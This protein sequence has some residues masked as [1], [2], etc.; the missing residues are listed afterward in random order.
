MSEPDQI[1]DAR[2]PD[3]R[4]RIPGRRRRPAGRRSPVGG[5]AIRP[6]V[7]LA[8]HRSPTRRARVAGRGGQGI[9]RAARLT[10]P[11]RSAAARPRAPPRRPGASR[12][13]AASVAATWP[14]SH[15]ASAA[16]GSGR[17]RSANRPVS[18]ACVMDDAR[19]RRAVGR[20]AGAEDQ[21]FGVVGGVEESAGPPARNRFPSTEVQQRRRPQS[22]QS[23]LTRRP[24][25]APAVRRP[26]R[27]DRPALRAGADRSV[28]RD[29]GTS[30]RRPGGR[31]SGSRARRRRPR[32]TPAGRAAAPASA[33][34]PI[35]RPLRPQHDEVVPAG[36]RPLARRIEQTL[37]GH[38]GEPVGVRRVGRQ[39]QHRTGQ[40]RDRCVRSVE[41]EACAAASASPSSAPSTSL[42]FA[43][44]STG[45]S[46]PRRR[47]C[48]RPATRRTPPWTVRSSREQ[49][50]GHLS[51]HPGRQ[52][53]PGH[54]GR[55]G[56]T[57]R[58]SC[59]LS[60]SIFS[61]CGTCQD[62][63]TL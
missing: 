26:D 57:R 43:R 52:R 7:R 12:P 14:P 25:T 48:R 54:A 21:R 2:S 61:K 20:V 1:R 35:A 63:S 5:R 50:F 8:D 40:L 30:G 19:R 38:V 15:G 11:R 37:R 23:R 45:R 3:G 29:C 13:T 56:R 22:S 46:R 53:R 59:A 51:R 36:L 62:R 58:S 32:P 6:V 55:G 31:R 41:T 10:R 60:S 28:P 33:S 39:S 18:R 44:G 47:R 9:A 42:E 49:E 16:R 27:R 17:L 4:R 24:D 34:A